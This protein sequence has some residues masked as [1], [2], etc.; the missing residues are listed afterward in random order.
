ML[1]IIAIALS[2][3]AGI[4]IDNFP[5]PVPNF[6]LESVSITANAET[7]FSI[8]TTL[9]TFGELV[10]LGSLS[11]SWSRIRKRLDACYDLKGGGDLPHIL[12]CHTLEFSVCTHICNRYMQIHASCKGHDSSIWDTSCD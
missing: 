2:T 4:S 5:N 11:I 7:N 1:T 9:L 8:A 3:Q 6:M 10:H 12:F